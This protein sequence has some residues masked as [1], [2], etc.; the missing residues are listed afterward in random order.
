MLKHYI[1]V[2]LTGL[3][4]IQEICTC[5]SDRIVSKLEAA[6]KHHCP[7]CGAIHFCNFK[8][9]A[10]FAPQSKTTMFAYKKECSDKKYDFYLDIGFSTD[11]IESDFENKKT[12]LLKNECKHGHWR[13]RF[14]AHNKEEDILVITNVDTGVVI[15]DYE[16]ILQ[17]LRRINNTSNINMED[18]IV[19]TPLDNSR[20][21]DLSSCYGYYT[22]INKI[23]DFVNKMIECKDYCIKNELII[24]S[25]IDPMGLN[26][27]IDLSKTT[28]AEQLG[29]SNFMFK[30][31]RD[32]DTN[33]YH[34]PLQI[35][36]KIFKEQAVNYL[37][38]FGQLPG[39]LETHS[40][41]RMGALVTEANLSIKKLYKFLYK[42]APR[43]QGLYNP[44][45]TLNLLY[46]AFD[47]TK[48]LELPFDKN[49]KALQRYH[50]VLVKEYEIVKDEKRHQL[51]GEAVKEYTH[52]ELIQ[53]LS[54]DE[55]NKPLPSNKDKYAMILPKDAQ[56]LVLEGKNM[57]HCVGGYI[58]RVIDNN[59]I[60]L[61]LRRAEKLDNSF[62]TVEVDPDDMKIHQ[63]KAKNN[64]PI[65]DKKAKIFLEKWCAKKN[66]IW[67]GRW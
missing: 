66:I 44:K 25:G 6:K 58:D 42:E 29:L 63:V 8:D 55:E 20:F 52:L 22:L 9:G 31:L 38:T 26:G 28:P 54:Y 30:Y 56:D 11:V 62:V 47:L 53:K 16:T 48:K 24:K 65:E 10:S 27:E 33:R 13:F 41:R 46:D 50:D 57:R 43:Q 19:N 2:Y 5:G 7:F 60:I 4:T 61:F 49:P 67:D 12:R 32:S 36:Q 39:G 18:N 3:D 34:H 1:H 45:E 21:M 35:I 14:N 40:I 64:R 37:N 15:E 23:E 51:F 17:V 59:S